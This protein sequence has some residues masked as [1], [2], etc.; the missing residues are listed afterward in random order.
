MRGFNAFQIGFDVAH[1]VVHLDNDILFQR[2]QVQKEL[3]RVEPGNVVVRA[4]LPVAER[5]GDRQADAPNRTVAS[6]QV[7]IVT[8]EAAAP[9]VQAIAALQINLRP[10]LV[11]VELDQNILPRQ[12]LLG[13]QV[14]GP[15]R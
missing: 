6:A 13:A 9:A 4:R 10:E 14:I 3:V 15:L 7:I 5:N 8:T 2:F 12:T 1:G 11:A